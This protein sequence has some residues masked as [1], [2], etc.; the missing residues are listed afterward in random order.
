MKGKSIKVTTPTTI[1]AVMEFA[2]GAQVT[3]GASWDVWKH[4][5]PNPIE[6]YGEKGSMLV[7][8]PNFFGGIVS[9]S[10]AGGDYTPV[11]AATRGLRRAEL[12]G[13]RAAP[14]QLPHARG[15]RPGRRGQQG[16]A[17]RAARAA[18]PPTSS[19]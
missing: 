11:D 13:G 9:Y 16:T 6:L 15:R 12:A 17:S 2:N 5:H 19:T 4:G 1:N 10:A 18:S 14:G 8:D 3:L 7:P